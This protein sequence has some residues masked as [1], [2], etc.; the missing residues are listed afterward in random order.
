MAIS[1]DSIAAGQN[2]PDKIPADDAKVRLDTAVAPAARDLKIAGFLAVCGPLLWYVQAVLIA[3]LI[4]GLARGPDGFL[5]PI[6]AIAAFVVLGLIRSAIDW[7]A[8]GAAF[9]AAD[10]V[11]A[12]ERE[13]LLDELR[14]PFAQALAS[15][16]SEASL[17]AIE[18]ALGEKGYLLV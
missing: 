12:S 3:G 4:S 11:M 13:R 15:S 10:K 6:P 5:S 2:P 9:R 17:D 7:L 18:K 1:T 8:G 16:E 14:E